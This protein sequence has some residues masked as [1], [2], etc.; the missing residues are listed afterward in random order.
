M[1]GQAEERM[2]HSH[3]ETEIGITKE[4]IVFTTVKIMRMIGSLDNV[5]DKGLETR[6][7][8][9]RLQSIIK[10][11]STKVD[12]VLFLDP[13]VFLEDLQCILAIRWIL[14]QYT[15]GRT[16]LRSV[17]EEG[18]STEGIPIGRVC[19]TLLPDEGERKV[20]G[21]PVPLS[22]TRDQSEKGQEGKKNLHFL[23]SKGLVQ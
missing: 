23:R 18:S 11:I 4:S 19:P 9:Q 6:L 7:R 20:A 10:P 8:G 15:P 16:V 13:A 17:L 14:A 2:E 22:S 21:D 5:S 3:H 12:V 1:A